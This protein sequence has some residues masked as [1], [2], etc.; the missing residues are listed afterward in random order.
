M[1]EIYNTLSIA[2]FVLSAMGL[3]VTVFLWFKFSIPKVFNDLSGRTAKKSIEKMR[4]ANEESGVKIF[5]PSPANVARG[6]IT[7]EISESTEQKQI[8]DF[9]NEYKNA[10]LQQEDETAV[11]EENATELLREYKAPS[12]ETEVDTELLSG[13]EASSMEMETCLL[14]STEELSQNH[15]NKT[16]AEEFLVLQEIILVHTQEII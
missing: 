1:A 15:S 14:G 3:A 12:T 9:S 6:M 16:K 4:K 5:R 8:S 2:A 13:E 11:L 10:G 7:E